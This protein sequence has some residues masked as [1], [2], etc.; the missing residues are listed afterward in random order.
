MPILSPVK[1]AFTHIK[2]TLVA[3]IQKPIQKIGSLA[4]VIYQYRKPYSPPQASMVHL[5][6]GTHDA[7]LKCAQ[8]SLKAIEQSDPRYFQKLMTKYQLTP[9]T[10]A[11]IAL[12]HLKNHL[13][14]SGEYSDPMALLA[15]KFA[16]PAQQSP[17]Q[18]FMDYLCKEQT[19]SVSTVEVTA[20]EG[21]PGLT[22]WIK[23][24]GFRH[25]LITL[26]NAPFSNS[27]LDREIIELN[28]GPKTKESDREYVYGEYHHVPGFVALTLHNSAKSLEDSRAYSLIR[29]RPWR[30]DCQ[31]FTQH[32]QEEMNERLAHIH[33]SSQE[34]VTTHFRYV[35]L[36]K[37]ADKDEVNPKASY[38]TSWKNLMKI[39]RPRGQDNET[40]LEKALQRGYAKLKS[41]Q[42]SIKSKV[43]GVLSLFGWGK[44]RTPTRSKQASVTPKRPMR[45]LTPT[46]RVN[47]VPQDVRLPYKG[48]HFAKGGP[49]KPD[50]R[51]IDSNAKIQK[52]TLKI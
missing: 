38:P 40:R 4:K 47:S 45:P 20:I 5:P 41:V 2:N 42:T 17:L 16:K 9:E 1:A 14:M 21:I 43:K 23:N 31:T 35:P 46:T 10:M 52:R 28:P 15:D 37:T 32:V 36:G 11:K 29:Y 12:F 22:Q 33:P 44:K 50:T 25:A 24:F 8:K 7:L 51:H 30:N 6:E 39:D 26:Y 19:Y 3:P 34:P 49:K 48:L 18:N 13:N 27:A